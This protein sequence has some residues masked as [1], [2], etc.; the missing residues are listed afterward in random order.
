MKISN[1][2]KAIHEAI[3]S[4]REYE[5]LSRSDL[6]IKDYKSLLDDA[7]GLLFLLG[8][9]KSTADDLRGNGKDMRY[10]IAALKILRDQKNKKTLDKDIVEVAYHESIRHAPKVLENLFKM[11]NFRPIIEDR[12]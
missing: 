9:E 4:I 12:E 11:Y 8:E 6:K 2:Y 1:I 3:Y 7:E 5:S 10:F